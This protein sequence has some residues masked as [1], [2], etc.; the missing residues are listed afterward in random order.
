M[1][2]QAAP[3]SASSSVLQIDLAAIAANYRLLQDQLGHAGCAAAVKADAYGT[4]ATEVAP[5]LAAAGCRTFFVA[6]IDEGVR[7]RAILP[8]ST[9]AVLNGVLAGDEATFQAE[10]LVPVI[11][12][13]GQLALWQQECCRVE[14]R[15][16]AMLHVDTGMNRL[17]LPDE[18]WQTI[19]AEPLRLRHLGKLAL[20]SHLACADD[21][22]HPA[23]V[24]QLQRFAAIRA[25]LPDV[26]ASLANSAGIFLGPSYHFDFARPGI[27]LYGGNPQP[28]RRNPMHQ[29]VRLMGRV[30]QI[31]PVRA[32]M[33]VGYGGAHR[34][35]GPGRIATIAVGYADGYL[36]AMGGRSQVRLGD[37]VL[38]VVGRV[39]MDLITVDVSSL[40]ESMLG[41]GGLVE[42]LGTGFTVDQAADAAGTISYE[43]LTGL[44]QR[45]QRTYIGRP[46]ATGPGP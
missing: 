15:L 21:V 24:A 18:E 7:L 35:T 26:R 33:T 31:R 8:D 2:E 3:A 5:A 11:N 37:A 28:Q 19:T 41:P 27:A 32:G 34:I 9:I 13:L 25:I 46:V 43:I 16:D 22:D 10:R 45:F 23:N 12:D 30:L 44:G 17:G 6:T 29:V 4:G 42:V 14:T 38:P 36:R 1:P 39:S 20:L 40:P